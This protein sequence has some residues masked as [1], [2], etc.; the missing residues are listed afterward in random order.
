M[1][2]IEKE[3]CELTLHEFEKLTGAKWI[4]KL[5]FEDPPVLADIVKS[6]SKL[7]KK[8]EMTLEQ[9][10]LGKYFQK[11]ISN[12]FV[13]DVAIRWIDPMMGWGVFALRDFRDMQF[14]AE[15]TGQVRKRRK[16][17]DKNAYCFEYVVA[18]GFRCPYTIDAL[19][20]GGL[21]RY[22]NHSETPNLNSSLATFN[23]V[24]HVV[25]YAKGAIAKGTQLCYDYGPDYW[26]KRTAPSPL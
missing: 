20:Q 3:G 18:Q 23:N 22:I 11:E 10:W 24:S 26:S 13:P 19:D 8:G 5:E 16:G 7:H 12:C 6:A 14:I 9:M 2:L 17:D 1:L 15:Y 25:L 21:G 4:P